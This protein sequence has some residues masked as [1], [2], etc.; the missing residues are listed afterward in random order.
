MNKQRREKLRNVRKELKISNEKLRILLDE[1]QNYYDNMPEN[2]QSSLRASYS[3]DAIDIL[4]ECI[5]ELENIIDKLME[6]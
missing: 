1:E 6:I 4:E 2:L 5:E 3:E